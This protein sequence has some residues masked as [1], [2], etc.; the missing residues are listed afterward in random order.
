M[1]EKI[2]MNCYYCHESLSI[3]LHR[4]LTN[5]LHKESIPFYYRHRL[6]CP[7]WFCI[8]IKYCLFDR[9]VHKIFSHRICA[10]WHDIKFLFFK[11]TF[12]WT[13]RQ[14]DEIIVYFL[15]FWI[16]LVFKTLWTFLNGTVWFHINSYGWRLIVELPLNR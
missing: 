14:F 10:N 11:D 1:S 7:Y 16:V 6:F 9:E 13:W 12:N 8:L 4:I 15:Q 5:S 2:W 3:L